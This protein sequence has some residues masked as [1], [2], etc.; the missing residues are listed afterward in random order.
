MKGDRR[1]LLGEEVVS[2][3]GNV[4]WH[5][6]VGDGDLSSRKSPLVVLGRGEHLGRS[7]GSE[8]ERGE[9]GKDGSEGDHGWGGFGV[10]GKRGKMGV[11]STQ[12]L[13]LRVFPRPPNT[14]L[15]AQL[16]ANKAAPQQSMSRPKQPRCFGV[17]DLGARLPPPLTC[18]DV[19]SEGISA[20]RPGSIAR[21]ATGC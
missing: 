18:L 10:L 2:E 3:Q 11:G 8:E 7:V 1:D 19:P 9:R 21:S 20:T 14:R 13:A 12:T 6:E 4:Q 15:S 5:T 16:F 17:T